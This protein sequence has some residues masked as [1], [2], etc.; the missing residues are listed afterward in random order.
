MRIPEIQNRLRYLSQKHG[1]GELMELADELSRR[2]PT[3]RVPNKSVRMNDTI[4]GNIIRYA[5]THPFA[6]QMEI[7]TAFKVNTGRV[8]ETLRGFRD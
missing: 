3:R 2:K 6:T 8:S 4:R 1:V 5:K 7:A